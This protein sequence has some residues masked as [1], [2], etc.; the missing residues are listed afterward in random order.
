MTNSLSSYSRALFIIDRFK[1]ERL[2]SLLYFIFFIIFNQHIQLHSMIPIFTS[3]IIYITK[4]QVYAQRISVLRPKTLNRN[5]EDKERKKR[6]SQLQFV[7]IVCEN[8]YRNWN[9]AKN[10]LLCYFCKTSRWKNSITR[11]IY[12]SLLLSFSLVHSYI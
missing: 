9:R 7:K 4:S 2:N 6:E 10:C 1:D 11:F 8:D 3:K 5:I 12:P